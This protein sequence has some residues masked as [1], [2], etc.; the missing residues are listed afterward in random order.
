VLHVKVAKIRK[1]SHAR[2]LLFFLT[3][4]NYPYIKTRFHQFFTLGKDFNLGGLVL[5]IQ[6]L[7]LDSYL[8]QG[9]HSQN[10][11][12]LNPYQCWLVIQFRHSYLASY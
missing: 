10:N 2:Y 5:G 1:T 9:S 12:V 4:H 6:V 11:N 8:V 3:N 7:C